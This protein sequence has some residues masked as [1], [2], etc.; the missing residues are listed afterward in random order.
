MSAK[1]GPIFETV[2]LDGRPV[3]VETAAGKFGGVVVSVHTT[4]THTLLMGLPVEHVSKA[5]LS[6]MFDDTDADAIL[7][8]IAE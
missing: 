7:A 8:R 2:A 5:I 3:A 1:I 4:D 6:T